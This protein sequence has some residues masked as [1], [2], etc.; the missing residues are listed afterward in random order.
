MTQHSSIGIP[1]VSIITP[2]YN[3]GRFLQETIESVLHQDYPHIEHIVVDGAS[4]D[5]T[6]ALLRTYGERYPDRFRWIS[7]PDGGQSEAINKAIAMVKGEFIGWQNS[8]DYYFPNTFAEPIQYLRE[9]PDVAVVYSERAYLRESG[10]L[11]VSDGQAYTFR[12]LL[13]NDLIPNQ[14]AF[15][16]TDALRRC[17]GVTLDLHYA[18]DYD[19]WLRLG[20]HH[21]MH[22]LPGVRGVWRALPEVKT[23][24]GALQS[25]VERVSL[26][27]RLLAQH[28]FPAQDRVYAEGA[29]QRH[30]LRAMFEALLR[31]E[32]AC[33]YELLE[34]ALIL[35][36]ILSQWDFL[37]EQ[38]LFRRLLLQTIRDSQVRD[39]VDAVPRTTLAL[40]HRSGHAPPLA[41]QKMITLLHFFQL[42]GR[43]QRYDAPLA[44]P[45]LLRVLHGHPVWLGKSVGT[46]VAWPLIHNSLVRLLHRAPMLAQ[47]SSSLAGH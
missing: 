12:R 14:A 13:N 33:A 18:M 2:S 34:K 47:P 29:L 3:H 26:F 16:R 8:D 9:H 32:E 30:M 1:L 40:L 20:L 25:L 28:D 6:V 7:E 17:G 46:A 4:T 21:K 19:L 15:L 31:G 37:C 24:A 23:I 41:A 27:E 35:D 11:R 38:L 36:G 43:I 22:Y 39:Q 42:L 44:V 10:E 45:Q 5:G